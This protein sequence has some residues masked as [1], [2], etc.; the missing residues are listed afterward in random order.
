[1][2]LDVGTHHLCQAAGRY[3]IPCMNKAV[4]VASAFLDLFPH[5][6][7]DFHVKDICDQVQCVLVVLYFGIEASKVEA[8][9]QVVFV[10]L[11]EVFVAS[12]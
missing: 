4:E 2:S 1:M 7:V 9:C 12:R 3:H 10:Y 5:V 11:A 6:V 8:V